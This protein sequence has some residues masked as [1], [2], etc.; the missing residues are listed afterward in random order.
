[1][2][3]TSSL[4]RKFNSSGLNPLRTEKGTERLKAFELQQSLIRGVA[5][6]ARV[7]DSAIGST[8][9]DKENQ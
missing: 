1:V 3:T 7:N 5:G 9:A 2:T 8:K 6:L 4:H